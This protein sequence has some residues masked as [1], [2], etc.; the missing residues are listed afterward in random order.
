MEA[1]DAQRTLGAF[2]APDGSFIRQLDVL[3]EKLD[4]WKRCLRNMHSGNLRAKW[5]SYRN[6]FLRKIMYPLIGHTLGDADLQ[7]LQKPVD[8]EI[9][10]IMGLNEHFPRVVLRG[11]L[12]YGGLGCTSLHG[13]HIIDK[14]VLFVHHIRENKRIAE[15]FYTSMSLTQLECGVSTPFIDLDPVIWFPLVTP[16]WITCLWRDC[17]AANIDIKMHTDCFWTP[18]ATRKNDLTIM[19]VANTMY[20]GT[21]LVQLNQCRLFLQVTYL[22]DIASVDGTRILLS[23]Y[24]GR[25]HSDTGRNTRLTW[26]PMGDL[27]QQYW[28]LWQEFL[29]RWCG[30]S[31]RIPTRLGGWF[32]GAEVLTRLC[33]FMLDRRLLLQNN[34]TYLEFSPSPPRSRTRYLTTPRPFTDVLDLSRLRAADI[35]FK[36]DSIYVI[37]THSIQDIINSRQEPTTTTIFDLYTQLPSPSKDL[38]E[39]LIGPLLSHSNASRIPYRM[40]PWWVLATDP[41]V[42]MMPSPRM[43]GFSKLLMVAS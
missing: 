2:I 26:P 33:F 21:Q 31:L 32:Q 9:L 20:R 17:K 19:S 37:S 3:H 38:L 36:N 16:T 7:S 11:P 30:S 25:G 13:Q 39:K 12:L 18:T 28:A 10:H 6:V 34:D 41:F 1:N 15:V 35:T 4:G 24:N 43:H 29:E 5:L 40:E 27:P 22:S 42:T 8:V 14:L 23:Y